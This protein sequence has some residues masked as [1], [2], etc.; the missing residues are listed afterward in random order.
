MKRPKI[1]D[2]RAVV[3]AAG[4]LM[5]IGHSLLVNQLALTRPKYP[6]A[7]HGWIYPVVNRATYYVSYNE[8][9]LAVVLQYGSWAVLAFI[10]V[11]A[12]YRRW[13]TDRK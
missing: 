10:A 1:G 7:E 12:L 3:A 2:V 9:T 13:V 8:K 5:F 6:D 4:V 11:T